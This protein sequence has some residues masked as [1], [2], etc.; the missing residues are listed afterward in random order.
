MKKL[1]LIVTVLFFCN[2]LSAQTKTNAE[3]FNKWEIGINGGVANYSGE[4]QFNGLKSHSTYDWDSKAGLG[5]G[6][7]LKKNFNHVFALELNWNQNNI[8]TGTNYHGFGVPYNEPNY[9]TLVNEYS[10]NSVWNINNLFSANRFDR[11]VYIYGKVGLGL[12]HLNN[13]VGNING[14]KTEFPSIPLG[15]GISV[16]LAN[17]IRANIGTQWS[18]IYSDRL[19]GK[20]SENTVKNVTYGTKLYTYAGLSFSLNHKKKIVPIVELPKPQPRVEPKP[21]PKPIVVPIQKPSV[22]GKQYKV[23]FAFDKWNLNDKSIASLDSLANNM[24]E[25]SAVNVNLKSHTDSRGPANYN[26]KLSEKRGKSV[27]DYLISKGISANR[28]NAQAFGETQLV[29]KCKDGVKCTEV[30][31]ALNRRTESVIIE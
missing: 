17:N 28:I 26:M 24:K 27:I 9:K 21:E 30:E 13:K 8:V 1:L 19:D 31:H 3:P 14:T 29:N 4:Y 2:F 22:V 20:L 15:A 25:D 10:L 11:N 6:A 7:N 23:Y 5:F 16:K 12:A 18:W